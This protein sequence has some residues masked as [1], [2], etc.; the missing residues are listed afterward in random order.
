MFLVF[1][2]LTTKI[3]NIDKDKSGEHIS[4]GFGQGQFWGPWGEKLDN[5]YNIETQQWV[6]WSTCQGGRKSDE[7]GDKL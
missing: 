7:K 6:L 4:Q 5:I 2:F 1:S 3:E